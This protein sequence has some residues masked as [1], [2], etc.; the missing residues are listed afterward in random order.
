MRVLEASTRAS[1]RETSIDLVIKDLL[2]SV[3]W[4]DATD[5]ISEGLFSKSEHLLVK[6]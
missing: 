1:K 6:Q 4:I 3:S 5:A 2:G